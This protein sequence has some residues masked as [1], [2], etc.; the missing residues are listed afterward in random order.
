MTRKHDPGLIAFTMP[1]SREH[2]RPDRTPRCSR[3]NSFAELL[4]LS[5]KSPRALWH[6][7]D[8][9]RI[10]ILVQWLRGAVMMCA[11]AISATTGGAATNNIPNRLIDYDAF[12]ASA[13]EVGR[14]REQ[15]RVTEEQFIE[16][17]AAP[18]TIIF[19]ARSDDK[20]TRLHIKG[21]RHLS[22][23]E[24]TE[25]ELARVLPT[26]STRILIYCNNNF[27]N[28]PNTFA[29]KAPTASLNIH[30]FNTLYNYGYT[31]VYE[32]GPLLD[33]RKTKL[34][35]EGTDLRTP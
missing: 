5:D 34:Q 3:E 18:G 31:N 24:I 4:Q 22:F 32:L 1:H 10:C 13:G 28:A 6:G 35:F 15:H 9:K 25:A 33:I 20:Y 21:A 16:M 27:L 29:T 11:V 30:T 12:L 26:K 17:S 14:L 7:L 8:M 19:D 2:H 23:P